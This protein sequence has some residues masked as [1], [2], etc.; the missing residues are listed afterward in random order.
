MTQAKVKFTTFEEYLFYSDAASIE[1]RY[2][3]IHGE[4]AKLPPESEVNNWIANHLQFLLA[5]SKSPLR[6]IKI[7][8]L[9]LQVPGPATQ[10]F[11]KSLP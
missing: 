3:L 2:E 11:C 4:L 5:A 6:L 7:Q 1:G 8:A 9:E 10:R